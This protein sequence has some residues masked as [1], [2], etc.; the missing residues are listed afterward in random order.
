[1]IEGSQCWNSK[2]LLRN[3]TTEVAVNATPTMVIDPTSTIAIL[4][5]AADALSAARQVLTSESLEPSAVEKLEE[6]SNSFPGVANSFAIQAGRESCHG[7]SKQS[8]T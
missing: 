4:V 1:M 5:A 6:I 3:T 8:V 2:K 7:S